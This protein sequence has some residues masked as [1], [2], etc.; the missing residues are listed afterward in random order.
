[1]PGQA[2]V[3]GGLFAA[4]EQRNANKALAFIQRHRNFFVWLALF[5]LWFGGASGQ[6]EIARYQN[7]AALPPKDVPSTSSSRSLFQG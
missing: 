2:R 3:H 5:A 7:E 4:L 1:M 6:G